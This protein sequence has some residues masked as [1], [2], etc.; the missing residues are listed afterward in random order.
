MAPMIPD[1]K[2]EEIREAA[3]LIEV[4]G[5][6]VKLKKSG[7]NWSGLCPFHDE[8]TPSFYVTPSMGI[9]KCFGC[10]ESGDVFN[11]VMEM[12]GLGFIEAMRSLA[13]RYG[14]TLPDPDEEESEEHHLREGIYHALKYAGTWY[15]HQ[16]M[17]SDKAEKARKYLKERGYN[18]PIIQKYGLGYAPRGGDRFYET[19]IDSGINEEYLLEAGLIKPSTRGDGYYD[20]FRGRL[21]FP[22]FSTSGKVIAFA[23]RILGDKKGAKYINSPQTKVYNKSE[24]LY[25]INFAK[26]TIRKND[27][28]ILVEGYTDVI[29]LHKHDVENVIASSGTSLTPKQLKMIHRYGES[30]TMIYDAD[31]AGQRAMKR[32]INLGLNEGLNVNL[33]ELPEDQDPDSFIKQFGKDSFLEL[34]KEGSEDFVSYL[35][36]KA[37]QQGNWEKPAQR[38]KVIGEV[39][40]SIAHINDSVAR[41]THVQYLNKLTKVGDRALFDELGKKIQALKEQRAKE[42]QRRKRRQAR[43]DKRQTV[44]GRRQTAGARGQTG[45]RIQ[46]QVDE[47]PQMP[48]DEREEV[49]PDNNQVPGGE[50]LASK[51]RPQYEKEIIRLMLAYDEDIIEFIGSY[52]SEQQFEDEQLKEFYHDIIERFK[53]DESIS[54]EVYTHKEHP[55]PQLTGEIVLERH[56]VSERHQEKTGVRYEKDQNKFATA[57]GAIKT[58]QLHHL[59]RTRQKLQRQ[60]TNAEDDDKSDILALMAEVSRRQTLLRRSTPAELFPNPESSSKGQ[61]EERVF[62]YKM[63]GEE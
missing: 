24:V 48:A 57:R 39:L 63:K 62:E 29:S 16:L 42:K 28:A 8:K 60:L 51:K 17:K 9:Y 41:E 12:E 61:V 49:Q 32:G 35:I 27:E 10:G 25:G 58:L 33:L 7:Q 55:Y 6:Y 46:E 59:D 18:R 30:L 23:G 4:V 44:N 26:N 5:D 15:H 21:M 13:D 47:R 52:C 53:A 20:A 45:N 50:Q 11:F 40:E 2:K 38:Q 37:K 22:I 54:A 3:D 19:A 14:V 36:N 56:E 1:D 43:N 31:S 34:K